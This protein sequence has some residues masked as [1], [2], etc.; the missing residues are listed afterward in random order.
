M[1]TV[2]YNARFVLRIAVSIN[3][4]DIRYDRFFFMN[5]A[6]LLKANTVDVTCVFLAVCSLAS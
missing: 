2:S 3:R 5:D 1:L 6:K 4:V